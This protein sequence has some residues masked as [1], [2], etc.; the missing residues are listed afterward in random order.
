MTRK[1]YLLADSPLSGDARVTGIDTSG[2]QPR[3][4]LDQTFF[5]VKGGGQLGDRGFIGSARV[6]DVR[7]AL[8]GD[9]DHLVESVDGLAVGDAVSMF[10]DQEHRAQNTRLHTAGH[11]IAGVM[12]IPFPDVSAIGAHHYPG[13]CRVEFRGNEAA[14]ETIRG[15]LPELLACAIDEDLSV[16]ILGNPEANRTIAIGQYPPI[17]CGGTHLRSVASLGKVEITGIKIKDGKLRVSYRL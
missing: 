10:V 11:L 5:H 1:L 17:P 7:H 8:N 4:I 13:E 12:A 14:M 9:V 3:I 2:A 16:Q 15:M 6:V